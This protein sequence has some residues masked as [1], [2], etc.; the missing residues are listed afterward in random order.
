[1]N[2]FDLINKV[3]MSDLQSEDKCLLIELI[4][5]SD[6]QWQS[7]PSVE[8]LCKVRGIKHE[9]NFKGADHYLPGL[10]TKVKKGRR[11]WYII[12]TPAVAGLSDATVVIKHTP[13]LA[14]T[15]ALEG[16]NTPAV[17]D[18]TPAV[19]GANTTKNTTVDTTQSP[20]AS[21][22]SPSTLNYQ[23][24]QTSTTPNYDSTETVY[25]IDL[26]GVTKTVQDRHTPAVEGVSKIRRFLSPG[27]K[28]E[29]EKQA[30]IYRATQEQAAEA[31]NKIE[32]MQPSINIYEASRLALSACGV[33]I[34]EEEDW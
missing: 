20:V 24:V 10:V 16:V 5:R 4:V 3:L 34:K 9:K 19:E 13:S 2:K 18:N 32:G 33:S 11:N 22:E 31:L 12:N 17:A 28:K 6:D 23:Y 7:R 27:E 21:D 25:M 30:R 1:M 26:A 15:P 29:F 14:D 8:R